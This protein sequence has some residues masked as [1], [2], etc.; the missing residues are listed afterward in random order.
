M[1]E[2]NWS[3]D[4]CNSCKRLV[5]SRLHELHESK[6]QFVSRIEFIRSKLSNFSAHV[7]GVIISSLERPAFSRLPLLP[8]LPP[9]G[10][11]CSRYAA[12]GSPSQLCG[13]EARFWH[14]CRLPVFWSGGAAEKL[15]LVAAAAAAELL[16]MEWVAAGLRRRR[17][18]AGGGI[19]MFPITWTN[20][21]GSWEQINLIS[22]T[23]RSFHAC[24]LC[25]RLGLSHLHEPKFTRL[26]R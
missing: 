18:S 26:F 13:G 20:K 7:S 6:L 11:L 16:L 9:S 10:H 24:N 2:T 8:S 22:E 5:P 21:N 15:A 19:P 25:K 23:D 14:G 17:D 3:F 1:R 12:V 4:S